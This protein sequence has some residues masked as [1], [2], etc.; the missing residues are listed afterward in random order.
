MFQVHLRLQEHGKQYKEAHL[1]RVEKYSSFDENGR[2]LFTP[3]LSQAT[4]RMHDNDEIN[5]RSNIN[6]PPS[7]TSANSIP[8][9]EYLYR[10]A[11]DRE[12]RMRQRHAEQEQELESNINKKKMNPQSAKLLIRKSV[13]T[14]ILCCTSTAA[15][16]DAAACC[17]IYS[18]HSNHLCNGGV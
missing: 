17:S 18:L 6:A 12:F 1:K 7:V 10:D 3:K 8:A 11:R 9:E 13:R 5:V 16:A 15:T 14:V 2:K 4:L